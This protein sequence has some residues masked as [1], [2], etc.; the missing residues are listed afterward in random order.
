MQVAV[1]LEER[2]HWYCRMYSR[3]I[4]RNTAGTYLAGVFILLQHLICSRAS[5]LFVPELRTASRFSLGWALVLLL[6]FFAASSAQAEP[7]NV[8]VVQSENSGLYL[9]FSTAL[10]EIAVSRGNTFAVIEPSR[11][12]PNSGLVI[13]VGVKAATA[14]AAS[15]APF[16]LNVLIPKTGHEKLLRDFPQRANAR[17][18]SAIFLD[19]P[20]YRQIHL[21]AAILPNKRNIGLLYSSPPDEFAQLKREIAEHGLSLRKQVV[22][23][24]LP[25]AEALQ[26]ILQDSEVLLALPDAA[27]Y[28]SST[29]RNILLATYRSGVPLIGLSPAYVKAGALCA[30]YSTPAQLA[31]QAAILIQK[32]SETGALPAAQYP[33]EFE[34]MVNEQVARSLGL[35]IKSEAVLHDEIKADNGGKQ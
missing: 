6:F 24:S 2:L 7:V 32:Y 14:V 15:N 19:Q 5:L 18:Y 31:L 30:V 11:P 1:R 29:I 12:I 35:N 20:V 25:L 3:T 10:R 34:V 8:T 21:V 17:A 23:P 4:K 33:Q 16:V 13:A 27:I 26:N 9:E 28:N 22:S